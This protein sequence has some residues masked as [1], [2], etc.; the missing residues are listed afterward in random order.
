VQDA[1]FDLNEFSGAGWTRRS[2]HG[3]TKTN[4]GVEELDTMGGVLGSAAER[5]V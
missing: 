4:A 5:S 2:G 1:S 3:A